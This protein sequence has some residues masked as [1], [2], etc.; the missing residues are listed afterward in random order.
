MKSEEVLVATWANRL[1]NHISVTICD[2]KTAICNLV[3]EYRYPEK[4]W[5]EP[6]HFSSLL[7]NRQD[8]V[9]ILLPRARA[10]GNN[11]QHIA[12]LLI[13]YDS[14][15]KL[16]LAEPSYLSVGNFDVVALKR[17]DGTTDTIYFTAQAPSPGNRHLYSTK[18]TP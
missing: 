7:S 8:A 2:Y 13:Q 12:K 16:E 4:M 5:A 15:G 3:F 10:N 17:Y 9:F 18:A 1:Q 11:Y 6:A 14:Q